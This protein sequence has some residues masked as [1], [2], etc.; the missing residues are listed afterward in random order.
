MKQTMT[1]TAVVTNHQLL[2]KQSI[3]I[4][5]ELVD[6]RSPCVLTVDIIP[7]AW[8][9]QTESWSDFTN[10]F[11]GDKGV[12]QFGSM[13]FAYI[14]KLLKPDAVTVKIGNKDD[15]T[16]VVALIL[17]YKKPKEEAT[18]SPPTKKR[19]AIAVIP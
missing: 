16:D 5:I 19:K 2:Q 6:R 12:Y 15:P 7:N 8:V 10:S 9:I 14:Q 3:T 11:K 1:G 17:S 4:Q 13:L 18:S